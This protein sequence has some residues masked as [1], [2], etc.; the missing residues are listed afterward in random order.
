M[1]DLIV[2]IGDTQELVINEVAENGYFTHEADIIRAAL[3]IGLKELNGRNNQSDVA[4]SI[5]KSAY[6]AKQ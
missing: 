1:R 2:K 6:Q 4:L 5:Y 3:N